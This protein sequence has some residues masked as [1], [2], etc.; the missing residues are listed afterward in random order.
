ML[1][2]KEPEAQKNLRHRN[3]GFIYLIIFKANS[4]F[5]SPEM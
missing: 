2:A 1:R 5:W 3:C 4:L